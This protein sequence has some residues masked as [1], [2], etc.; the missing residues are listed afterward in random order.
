M[1][2]WRGGIKATKAATAPLFVQE[3]FQP[4]LGGDAKG[5]GAAGLARVDAV[6]AGCGE[7]RA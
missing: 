6:L 5:R 3:T 1:Y 4:C 7:G 2:L